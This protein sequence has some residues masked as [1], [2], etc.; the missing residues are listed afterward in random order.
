VSSENADR[1]AHTQIGHDARAPFITHGA[2]SLLTS[3][4]AARAA[5]TRLGAS[6][7]SPLPPQRSHRS[8]CQVALSF[9]PEPRSH[10]ATE[11]RSH[12]AI[13]EMKRANPGVK[14][15]EVLNHAHANRPS[16]LRERKKWRAAASLG[17]QAISGV[18]PLLSI[19]L[20][21]LISVASGLTLP[22]P[23]PRISCACAGHRAR[24]PMRPSAASRPRRFRL[25]K[26]SKAKVNFYVK[27]KRI[28]SCGQLG[29]HRNFNY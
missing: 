16:P 11:P 1:I 10:G 13:G 20:C 23:R 21:S 29:S 17:G 5:L 28:T 22:R 19:R 9:T 6:L 12:G 7:P 18:I 26:K 4:A 14:S 3:R 27:R 8:S 24:C 25:D 2:P 15:S